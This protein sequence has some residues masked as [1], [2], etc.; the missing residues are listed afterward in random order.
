MPTAVNT[1]RYFVAQDKGKPCRHTSA[2]YRPLQPDQWKVTEVVITPSEGLKDLR[3]GG[4]K[5]VGKTKRHEDHWES[6]PHR[7]ATRKISC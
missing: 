6:F 3:A 2:F 1:G 7:L 5:T 4:Q